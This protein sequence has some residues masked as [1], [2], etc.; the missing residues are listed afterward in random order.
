V[1]R[2]KDKLYNVPWTPVTAANVDTLL[3]QRSK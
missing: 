2:R 1:E 3:A